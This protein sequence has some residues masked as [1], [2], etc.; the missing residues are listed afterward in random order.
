VSRNGALLT[1]SSDFCSARG[2]DVLQPVIQQFSVTPLFC[3]SGEPVTVAWSI[4]DNP[5]LTTAMLRVHNPDGSDHVAGPLGLNSDSRTITL[6]PGNGVVSLD[7]EATNGVERRTANR[8]ARLMCVGDL[9]TFQFFGL[10][11]PEDIDGSRRWVLGVNLSAAE[12][13]SHIRAGNMEN[14]GT[15]ALLVRKAGQPGDVFLSPGVGGVTFLSTTTMIGE[16]LFISP[17]PAGTSP[18]P[19]FGVRVRLLC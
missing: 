19:N 3:C 10:A 5:R 8:R 9:S 4:A 14:T 11:L 17:E 15:R 13:S 18:A 1:F 6:A 2:L 12:W 7:L 16:W